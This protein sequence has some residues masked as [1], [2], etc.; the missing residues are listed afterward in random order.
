MAGD[1]QLNPN[2]KTRKNMNE[3]TAPINAGPAHKRGP[4]C[5]RLSELPEPPANDPNVF[6]G[7]DIGLL[8]K[9]GSMLVCGP[10]G[11]GKS[12][13]AGHLGM[14]LALG[15]SF[16][17]IPVHGDRRVLLVTAADEDGP[18][19]LWAQTQGLLAGLGLGDDRMAKLEAN[20]VICPVENHGD[21]ALR[22]VEQ[23]IAEVRPE[24]V[25]LNPL[26]HFTDGNPSDSNACFQLVGRLKTLVMESGAAL[27]VIHHTTKK[28]SQK[29]TG[30][31]WAQPHYGGAGANPLFNMFR[32]GVTLVPRGKRGE[33][34]LQFTKGGERAGIPGNQVSVSWI[35]GET[36]REGR[37]TIRHL[38]WKIV[39]DAVDEGP[40]SD[41]GFEVV[42]SILRAAG[43][44]LSQNEILAQWDSDVRKPGDSTLGKDLKRW[45]DEGSLVATRQGKRMVYSLPPTWPELEELA[46]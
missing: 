8:R 2:Q 12:T 35:H 31:D 24:V 13:F 20:L 28:A 26:Q 23:V 3:T 37:S 16:L 4:K 36:K 39:T 6:M 22:E 41:P 40:E 43:T 19:V 46:S 15:Q 42:N 17:G 14:D 11:C 29:E 44:V 7:V 25:I 45:S 1:G 32:S 30:T 18:E 33:A 21:A 34:M 38:G 10:T 5:Y 9:G 27:V